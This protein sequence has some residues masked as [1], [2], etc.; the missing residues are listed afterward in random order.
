M[1]NDGFL[2]QTELGKLYGVSRN[3]IGQW[4]VELGLRTA[5]K[6]PSQRAFDRGFVDRRDSTQPGTYYWVWHAAKTCELLD[7]GHMRASPQEA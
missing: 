3:T 5:D 6:K 2:S 1:S 7:V 4:L